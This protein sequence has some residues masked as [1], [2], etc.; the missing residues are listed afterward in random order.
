MPLR[1]QRRASEI[2]LLF[3]DGERV[4]D[5]TYACGALSRPMA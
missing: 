4:T 5:P 2:G 1:A 3:A